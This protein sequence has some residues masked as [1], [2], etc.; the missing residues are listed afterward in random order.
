ACVLRWPFVE[1]THPVPDLPDP[2][3]V[4]TLGQSAPV[5][6]CAISAD[7]SVIASGS[8]D[9]TLKLWD[10]RTGAELRTLAGHSGSVMGCAISAD[11]SIIVSASS[12]NT[13]KLWDA[14]TGAE[15]RTL[16]G[17]FGSVMGCAISAD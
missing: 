2:A 3:L 1:T 17:H 15:L 10:A 9:K 14:R 6:C 16:T 5:N 11:G 8:S 4:R 7:G 13:L 12:D